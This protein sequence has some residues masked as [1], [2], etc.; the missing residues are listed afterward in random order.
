MGGVVKVALGSVSDVAGETRPDVPEL[1]DSFGRV[2]RDLRVSLTDRCNLRCQY[3]M[4]AEGVQLLPSPT[5]LTD[6]EVIRLIEIAVTR[7]GIQEVRFTGG[8]PLLRK[9]LEGIV[10]ATA[11]L[12]THTGA[13]VETALTTNGLGLAHR[14]QALKAA[15][16][17]R[18]NISLDAIHRDVYARLTRRDRFN[19]AIAGAQAAAA[20]GLLPVKMNAVLMPGVNGSEVESLL[21][22]ALQNTFQLRYI[23]YM[24]LGPRG[25]WKREDVITAHDILDTLSKHF[26]F[27]PSAKLRGSSP[28]QLWDVEAGT[29]LGESHPAGS[30]GIIASVSRPFCGDCDR[31]R[32][33]AD[34]HLRSCL[35]AATETDLRGLIRSGA[36]DEEIAD[37]WRMAMWGKQ[38]GHGTDDESY[39]HPTRPMS[40]IG[41]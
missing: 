23:E 17:T 4:P 31:T 16:L 20:A 36:S 9:G 5:L 14:A 12:R 11:Q 41:G 13:P 35:F 10:A 38:A 19:D 27:H 22:Y 33:T 26:A 28:A 18:V 2:A 24:P 29:A 8:E 7:L 1:V 39:L 25:L 6:E 21:L 15:G 30:F 32:L 34:G 37:A 40:A 3:C